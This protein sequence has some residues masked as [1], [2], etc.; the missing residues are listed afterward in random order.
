ME[1]LPIAGFE[2]PSRYH[3]DI[4]HLMIVDAHSLYV[5][6]E[7]SDRRRWLISQHFECSYESMPKVIRLY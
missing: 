3:K 2:V 6:W 4:L 7:I 5:Y 1:A